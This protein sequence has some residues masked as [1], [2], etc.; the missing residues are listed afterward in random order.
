M[1]SVSS[2]WLIQRIPSII[3]IPFAIFVACYNSYTMKKPV[4]INPWEIAFCIIYPGRYSLFEYRELV[5]ET[6]KNVARFQGFSYYP[7]DVPAI[8]SGSAGK[9]VRAGEE[10]WFE[11]HYFRSGENPTMP[12]YMFARLVAS[13][14]Q[15]YWENSEMPFYVC[16]QGIAQ[17]R[18]HEL[19]KRALK[20]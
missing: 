7:P 17:M 13:I 15:R 5:H 9:A 19:Y 20:D 1:P 11:E 14:F 8:Y 18:A 6:L 3:S 4:I 2:L 12:R 16:Q 10:L